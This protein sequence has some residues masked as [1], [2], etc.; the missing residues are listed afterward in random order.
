MLEV[1]QE[2]LK[3]LRLQ[4][5]KKNRAY[6]AI[7]RQLD[8]IP[9]RTELAQYQR[10]FLELYNQGEFFFFAKKNC[11]KGSVSV[12]YKSRKKVQW[13]CQMHNQNGE[14]L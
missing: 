5:A 10:R 13:L 1:E 3:A 8:N 4:L 6:V 9:D 12:R 2:R 7:N 14:E 11:P